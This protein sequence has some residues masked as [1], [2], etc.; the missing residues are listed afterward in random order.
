MCSAGIGRLDWTMHIDTADVT[1]RCH[2][3]DSLLVAILGR[4][5]SQALACK[6]NGDALSASL[7]Q[8]IFLVSFGQKL[9]RRDLHDCCFCAVRG[10]SI[11]PF[12]TFY[13][14]PTE[15]ETSFDRMVLLRNFIPVRSPIVKPALL[16]NWQPSHK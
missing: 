6:A 16:F 7:L 10:L 11:I 8:R 15:T 13:H 14:S 9:P 4:M 1:M 5:I 3:M 2:G 12:C